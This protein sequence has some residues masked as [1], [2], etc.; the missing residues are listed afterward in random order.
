[1]KPR[2]RKPLPSKPRP[3]MAESRY[4]FG[5]DVDEALAPLV[6]SMRRRAGPLVSPP[7]CVVK[8]PCLTCHY[9]QLAAH[10][11]NYW[12]RGR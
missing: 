6:E 8:P 7:R 12:E 1:M 10:G 2:P 5:L 3:V 4:D 9:C 11:E